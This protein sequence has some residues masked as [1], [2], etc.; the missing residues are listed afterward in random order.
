MGEVRAPLLSQ[1]AR[2]G[3]P[4]NSLLP[5]VG[6]KGEIQGAS[7]SFQLNKNLYVPGLNVSDQPGCS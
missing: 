6:A 5:W 3:I 1:I 4:Q 2:D 7:F